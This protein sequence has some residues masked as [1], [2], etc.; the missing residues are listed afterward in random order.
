M[1]ARGRQRTGHILE[2]TATIMF[3]LAGLPVHEARR[4][5][6][7]AAKSGPKCLMSETNS[8]HRLLACKMTDQ[9]NADS[10]F[11]RRAWPRRDQYVVRRHFLHVMDRYLIIASDFHL[12]TQ[13]SQILHQV[14][15]KGIVVVENEDHGVLEK[16]VSKMVVL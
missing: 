11:L 14:V 4:P 10:S 5:H 2:Q 7:I 9:L 3:Y 1:I 12:L 8:K 13:L 15:G 16:L 6:H